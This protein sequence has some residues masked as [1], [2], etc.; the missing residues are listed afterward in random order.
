MWPTLVKARRTSTYRSS[1]RMSNRLER[2]AT[3]RKQRSASARSG[4]TLSPETL[5]FV[6]TSPGKGLGLFATE[7]LPRGQVVAHMREPARMTREEW[8]AHRQQH[9]CLPHDAA[10]YVERSPLLFYD[11]TWLGDHD[12]PLW[13]RLNHSAKPNCSMTIIDRTKPAVWK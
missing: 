10:I 13:Y 11:R 1:N 7:D 2:D 5:T 3:S 6:M 9:V 8:L 12:V 4:A